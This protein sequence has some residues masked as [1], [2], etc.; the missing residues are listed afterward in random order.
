MNLLEVSNLRKLYPVARVAAK[1][2]AGKKAAHS[3]L[4]A[5][6]DV[7]FAIAAGESVGLVGESGCG[8]STL[9]RLVTRLID[10]S[11]GQIVFDANDVGAIPAKQFPRRPE[12]PLIQMVFQDPTDSLNPRYTAFDTIAEPLRLLAGLNDA[13]TIRARVEEV[14]DQCGLPRVLLARFPHQL[15]GG[16]KARVGIARAISIK[17][18]LLILDEPTAALDVS[19]QSIILHLL[20]DLRESL[21]MSYLFVSH[22]L[23][24]VRLL[25]DRV[26]VMYLGKI[27]ECGPAEE[28]FRIPRHPYTRALIAA[29]PQSGS[30][31]VAASLQTEPRSPI[32]PDPNV[33]RFYGRCPGGRAECAE[34]APGLQQIGEQHIVACHYPNP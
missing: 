13:A 10:P 29:I 3:F 30:Q 22:D 16:Q 2:S 32:D 27:V 17:P 7:S 23:N 6:D 1:S 8:K 31:T 34:T 33:C 4:H 12:R 25:C 18:K 14:A 28:V 21:G 24:I 26:I 5:V 9:V 19:V 15:S 20:A 11:G